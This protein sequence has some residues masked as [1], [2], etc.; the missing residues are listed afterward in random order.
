[1]LSFIIIAA[2]FI[3]VIIGYKT[4]FNTGFFAIVFAYLIGAFLLGMTP[5]EIIS[6][7]P[8]STMFVIFSV[9]LFYNFALANGTLEKTAR[10]L[11]YAFRKAP[12][13]LP[14][15]LYAA[16]AGIAALGAGFFTVMA[17]MA[18]LTLLIC[19]EAKMSKLV[20]AIAIN[21][22]ALSG[23]NFMTSGSGIIYRGLMEGGGYADQSFRYTA[24]IFIASVIFSLLLIAFFRYVP[25][26]NRQIGQ[27]VTFDKPEPFTDLQKKNLS[28]MITMIL[29]VLIFP[30]LHIL[31]PDIQVITFINSKMDV[32][33]VAIIFS[34]IALFLKLAP[35]KEVIAKVPWNTIIM[36][37]GVGMLINVAISA[38]TIDLL[39][40]WAGSSLPA[41]FIP[42]AFSLIG[43]VMSFFSSTLGVVCPALFPLVSSLAH[44][45]GIDPMILFTCIVIGAQSSAIS[46][47]SSGGSLIMGSCATEEERNTMFPK[48]LFQAV[49]ISMI[50]AVLFNTVL[51]F[52][53]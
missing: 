26:S 1:M 23:A 34:A 10:W 19:D 38:G 22:G 11:L 3:A 43:A 7:W 41:W 14:F 35:Q 17:F 12:G 4:G 5:K 44:T 42:I 52:L 27:G 46:P 37:C 47:F 30:V 36:I 40:S 20:G 9:S 51:S 21:C 32:G 31:L 13:L 18:P 50:S 29:V 33:L 45:A 6:G 39:A 25:K 49:P 28:L 53:L 8:V 2:I 15:A 48:L 16:S 24:V